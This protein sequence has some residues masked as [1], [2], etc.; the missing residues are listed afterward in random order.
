MAKVAII[1]LLQLLGLVAVHASGCNNVPMVPHGPKVSG[2]NGYRLIVGGEPSGYEPGKTYN[3][4]YI[5][6]KS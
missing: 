6:C 4:E 2:D 1:V 5:R 3:C